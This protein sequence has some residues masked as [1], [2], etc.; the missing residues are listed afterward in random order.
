MSQTDS[1]SSLFR[2]KKKPLTVKTVDFDELFA[3]GHAMSAQ[4]EHGTDQTNSYGLHPEVTGPTI[5]LPTT[6]APS[7]PF[8]DYSKES[9]FRLSQKGTGIGYEEKVAS[10]LSDQQSTVHPSNSHQSQPFMEQV[11]RGVKAASNIVAASDIVDAPQRQN[12]APYYEAERPASA[13]AQGSTTKPPP[14]PRSEPPQRGTSRSPYNYRGPGKVGQSASPTP[15]G[16]TKAKQPLTPEEFLSKIQDFVKKAEVDAHLSQPVWPASSTDKSHEKP[17]AKTEHSKSLLAPAGYAPKQR[18]HSPMRPSS[19]SVFDTA[20][21]FDTLSPNDRIAPSPGKSYLDKPSTSPDP[22]AAKSMDIPP[23]ATDA[24]VVSASI[25]NSLRRQNK[26]RSRTDMDDVITLD[27]R[28]NQEKMEYLSVPSDNSPNAAP[29]SSHTERG[30]SPRKSPSINAASTHIPTDPY[31]VPADRHIP[32]QLKP[33]PLIGHEGGESSQILQAD[34]VPTNRY[35]APENIS[36]LPSNSML[37]PA[38][39]HIPSQLKPEPLTDQVQGPLR[40]TIV[41]PNYAEEDVASSPPT[42]Q[43]ADLYKKLAVGLDRLLQSE[44]FT[45]LSRRSEADQQ[46]YSHHLGRAEFGTLQKRTSSQQAMAGGY[47]GQYQPRDLSNE[48]PSSAMA[49]MGGGRGSAM[50]SQHQSRDSSLGRHDSRHVTN[51]IPEFYD[52]YD[53]EPYYDEYD[54]K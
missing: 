16:N 5:H 8:A 29:I 1:L 45:E 26:N 3:R 39:Q 4:F 14:S 7:T 9:A 40:Q 48:R 18:E 41:R 12:K 42:I 37:Q 54:S 33:D 51:T 24:S 19:P 6:T 36:Q 10:Y 50:S 11:K 21:N 32:N 49:R 23:S 44:K 27:L 52:S 15:S 2:R 17:T 47:S 20:I 28:Q 13:L 46:S 22:F 30:R 31:L 53:Y 34:I 43:D 25:L 35:Q 38:D